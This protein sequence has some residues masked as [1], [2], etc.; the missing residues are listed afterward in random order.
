VARVVESWGLVQ[1]N[2]KLTRSLLSP[3]AEVVKFNS[4]RFLGPETN[5]AEI[6]QVVINYKD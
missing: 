4:R 3:V 2:K 1:V 6:R 5:G